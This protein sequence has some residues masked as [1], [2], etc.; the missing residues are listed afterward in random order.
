[1]GFMGYSDLMQHLSEDLSYSRPGDIE[2]QIYGPNYWFILDPASYLRLND[3]H[4]GTLVYNRSRQQF[5]KIN[6]N[7]DEDISIVD[8]RGVDENNPLTEFLQDS[9]TIT[10]K[11]GPAAGVE[12]VLGPAHVFIR[13][14]LYDTAEFLYYEVPFGESLPFIRRFLFD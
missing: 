14:R 5:E 4:V 1:M 13:D 9:I 6:L 2:S 11:Y 7:P 8:F 12:Y 10:R 3:L